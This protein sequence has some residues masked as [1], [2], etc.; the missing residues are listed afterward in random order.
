M[1]WAITGELCHFDGFLCRQGGCP[2]DAKS[3]GRRTSEEATSGPP[4]G[5]DLPLEV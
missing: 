2:M 5:E 3:G 4:S 1:L